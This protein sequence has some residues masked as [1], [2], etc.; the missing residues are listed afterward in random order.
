MN[1]NRGIPLPL[2]VLLGTALLFVFWRLEV[3]PAFMGM[4]AGTVLYNW[5]LPFLPIPKTPVPMVG[6]L[7]VAMLV[8]GIIAYLAWGW[9]P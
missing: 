5:A 1:E 8:C 7:V 4:I 3:P 2:N 6:G 9:A